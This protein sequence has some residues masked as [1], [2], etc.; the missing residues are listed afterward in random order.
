MMSVQVL[1][2]PS[3]RRGHLSKGA[4]SEGVN[5]YL[6]E[7]RFQVEYIANTKVLGQ[8]W[9]H[10]MGEQGEG[11]CRWSKVGEGER[12]KGPVV[13]GLG[14][15]RM[16]LDFS[17]REVRALGGCGQR[18]RPDLGAPRRPLVA[19]AGRT[20]HRKQGGGRGRGQRGLCSP[21][22]RWLGA[23][24]S[25]DVGRSGLDFQPQCFQAEHRG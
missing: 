18:T 5:R 8:H 11:L 12:R 17:S 22:G 6:E 25:G 1:R 7:K 23:Q 20:G 19:T 16:D 4:N 14:D 13:Q 15:R 21:G 9:A 2:Q 3:G 24:G 10:V